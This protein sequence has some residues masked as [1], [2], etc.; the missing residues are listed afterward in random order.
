MLTREDAIQSLKSAK[1]LWWLS[2]ASRHASFPVVKDQYQKR[3]F[4]MLY[5]YTFT[6]VMTNCLYCLPWVYNLSDP[7]GN[8]SFYAF[9]ISNTVLYLHLCSC[10]TV[11]EASVIRR[12]GRHCATS[13]LHTSGI[14]SPASAARR[15]R[16]GGSSDI[17]TPRC[18]STEWAA[19]WQPQTDLD[20]WQ[21][22]P[23][24]GNVCLRESVSE[25]ER[26]AGRP[27]EREAETGRQ[28]LRDYET[29]SESGTERKR[30]S[31]TKRA[32][33]VCGV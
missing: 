28:R 6:F 22:A 32:R 8:F 20:P 7:K 1:A 3:C 18:W 2:P 23:Y 33:C 12:G 27:R 5:L 15:W 30:R 21:P 31:K 29:I 14:P 10:E 16:G 9:F 17:A 4:T 11:Q 25:R 19:P 24:H 13:L 26:Y